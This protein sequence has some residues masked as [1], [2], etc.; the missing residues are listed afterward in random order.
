MPYRWWPATL[1]ALIGIEPW[2][3]LQAL[4]A[5]LRLP[6]SGVALGLPVLSVWARTE[7][8]RPLIVVL[9]HE[10][11]LD[12]LIVGALDMTPDQLAEFEGWE[13]SCRTDD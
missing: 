5:D 11:G 2:E 3:A 13:A 1:A 8:G 4:N 6:R 10:G 12:W 9:R 7:A